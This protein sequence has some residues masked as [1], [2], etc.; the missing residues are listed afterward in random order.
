[1]S[2][3]ISRAPNLFLPHHNQACLN[4]N[5]DLAQCSF[6]VDGA[7]VLSCD[8]SILFEIPRFPMLIRSVRGERTR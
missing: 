4:N 2:D 1:M 7:P 6:S 5:L 8:T 3:R